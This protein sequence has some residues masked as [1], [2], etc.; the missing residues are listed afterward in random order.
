MDDVSAWRARIGSFAFCGRLSDGGTSKKKNKRTG[1][2]RMA[3]FLVSLLVVTG[4]THPNPGPATNKPFGSSAEN[5]IFNR[6]RTRENKLV[7]M[8]SH[9]E[10][11]FFCRSK[12]VVPPGMDIRLQTCTAFNKNQL[13][14][15]D[16]VEESRVG[17]LNMFIRHYEQQIPGLKA[18]LEENY[19]L[20]REEVDD[21]RYRYLSRDLTEFR[22]RIIYK[23]KNLISVY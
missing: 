16:F 23:L 7:R 3:L 18:S 11:W 22:R 19:Y 5:E 6:I 15:K 10:F 1:D 20:L 8:E 14:M 21:Q 4:S 2:I 12:G 9:L 17:L 13:D